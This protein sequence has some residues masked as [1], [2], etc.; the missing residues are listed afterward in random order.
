L[1]A[2]TSSTNAF[3]KHCKEPLIKPAR[4]DKVAKDGKDEFTNCADESTR[5]MRN[6]ESKQKTKDLFERTRSNQNISKR[7]GQIF[8]LWASVF[9]EKL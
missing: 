6:D 2:E 4:I 8:A 5:L 7:N 9:D 1:F 3:E